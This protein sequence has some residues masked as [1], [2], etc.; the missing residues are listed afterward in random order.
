[1]GLGSNAGKGVRV[2]AVD[3]HTEG[4]F[5]DFERHI[6]E[7]SIAKLI[8][9]IK[10]RSQEAAADFDEAIE[11]LFIDGAHQYELV[12]E[13]FDR[14][15]REVV[16]GGVVAMHDS[17]WFEGPQARGR[18]AHLQVAALQE[19]AL[20]LQLDDRRQGRWRRTRPSTG[21]ATAT[22]W[23]SSARSS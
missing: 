23:P 7:A 22:A 21:C 8:T 20:R 11:L 3:R 4:T 13:D 17:T 16:E 5:P 12:R 18:R 14:W 19:H 2:Y 6:E 1:M 10:G 15:V 9:P